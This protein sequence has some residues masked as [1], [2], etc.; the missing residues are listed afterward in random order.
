L[1]EHL[2]C[3]TLDAIT[4][5]GVVDG[6]CVVSPDPAVLDWV[7]PLDVLPVLQQER[8]LNQ[9]LEHARRAILAEQRIDA[10]LVVLPDLPLVHAD[11]ITALVQRSTPH[12][13]VLAPDRHG[14]GT[15]ALLV[16]PADA[17]PVA[18]GEGS[19]ARHCAAAQQ[20]QLRVHVFDAQGTAFDVDTLD[21]VEALQHVHA[22]VDAGSGNGG[23]VSCVGGA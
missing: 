3:N 14:L 13:V 1:V 22:R 5:S 2:F 10:L 4:T 9:G 17:M 23:M 19:F 20:R 21:D 15:N 11:N 18:F 7:A 12:S 16:R 6:V 8:G